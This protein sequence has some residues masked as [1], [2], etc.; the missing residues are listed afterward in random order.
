MDC[1]IASQ[2][3]LLAVLLSGVLVCA[4]AHGEALGIVS[5]P[6]P[7]KRSVPIEDGHM[8]PYE[9]QIPGTTLSFEML[10]VPGGI[11]EQGS[12]QKD[13]P[14]GETPP[15]KVEVAPFWMG[16]CE[17]TWAEY[18]LFMKLCNVFE[19]FEEHGMRPVTKDNEIDAVT[20]PSKLYDPSFTFQYGEDPQKT[21]VSMSQFAAKQY[22]KWLSLLTG[23]FYRLPTE[24][25]WEYACRAGSQTD[26][27]Y[28]DDAASLDQYAWFEDNSDYET[29]EV[30]QKL[31][32]KWGFHDITGNA[33]EWVMDE[34]RADWYE[35]FQGRLFTS[36]ETLCWPE[37]LYPRVLRG[38]SI[39]SAALDC[40][41]AA[42]RASDDDEF[43]SYDP[44]TPKSPWW[45]ASDEAL[46]IG[47]RIVRPLEKISREEQEKF[48]QADLRTISRDA[49]K[50]IFEEGR[51]E[52]GLV[53]PQLPQAMEV[54]RRKQLKERESP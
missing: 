19:G 20:G 17:V 14:D 3:M 18:K 25:E 40:R 5:K 23:E 28:G 16:K 35:N 37:K 44:N 31:P 15:V 41:S 29:H 33:A 6:D 30:G 2:K 10:P 8:V 13:A 43:R 12:S 7:T 38:G 32:N 53:D 47:F 34:Y 24:S 1:M 49:N 9:H 48:W 39:N 42:R 22:T 27:Y 51:G 46:D 11:F 50:R 4:D 36:D 26:Y 54:L 45:F 21:A 52:R